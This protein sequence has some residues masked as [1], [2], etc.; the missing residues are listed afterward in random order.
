MEIWRLLVILL[1]MLVAI[2]AV[3]HGNSATATK[4]ETARTI[5][6]TG[7]V[8]GS[9]DFDGSANLSITTAQ[10]NIAVLTGTITLSNGSGSVNFNYPTG[11]NKNNCV[12]IAAGTIYT[13]SG[14][15]GFGFVQSSIGT[16]VIMA[17]S[18]ISLRVN[19]ISG[20]GATGTYNCK[21]VLMKTN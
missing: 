5:K 3:V 13:S 9:G 20:T 10:A 4:L 11:Y 7:A 14:N 17:D 8:S 2:L 12:P 19:P 18:E 6:L 1:V 16:G 15:Y 21:V